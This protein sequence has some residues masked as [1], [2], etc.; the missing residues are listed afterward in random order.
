MK[1]KDV[2]EYNDK[3]DEKIKSLTEDIQNL[4]NRKLSLDSADEIA[5]SITN[6]SSWKVDVGSGDGSSVYI[7][8]DVKEFEDFIGCVGYDTF[9][10][11]L[12]FN[13]Y[14][15]SIS[16]NPWSLVFHNTESVI[17]FFVKFKITTDKLNFDIAEDTKKYH[18]SSIVSI[19]KAVR[20][21]KKALLD[22]K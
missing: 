16:S 11:L 5:D 22:E 19:D 12:P 21:I 10:N 3:I 13:T 17:N 7:Y 1:L 8:P 9:R 18:Y 20:D 4:S 15:C 2:K 14:N 6:I